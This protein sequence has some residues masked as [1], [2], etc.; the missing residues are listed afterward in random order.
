MTKNK[1]LEII[2]SSLKNNPE[3]QSELK[4]YLLGER[5]D[6]PDIKKIKYNY[7]A[8]YG[9]SY[10]KVFSEEGEVLDEELAE[11][12]KKVAISLS[13][14][15]SFSWEN[16]FAYMKT[17]YSIFKLAGI[18]EK[19]VK[20]I[21]EERRNFF[22]HDDLEKTR[23]FMIN[24]KELV[25][26]YLKNYKDFK[27]DN[28]IFSTLE[29]L[30][31]IL[32]C[33]EIGNKKIIEMY[34]NLKEE[35]EKILE[36]LY[37]NIIKN[38]FKEIPTKLKEVM[39]FYDSKLYEKFC[40]EG[41]NNINETTMK[42]RTQ[43]IKKIIYFL[44][45]YNQN[46]KNLSR[47]IIQ[48]KP[49]DFF[50][51]ENY[52]VALEIYRK[53]ELPKDIMVDLLCEKVL[54]V[55][56]YENYSKNLWNEELERVLKE[57]LDYLKER[58]EREKI[59]GNDR[60]VLLLAYGLKFDI[61]SEEKK[62]EYIERFEKYA[63]N[64][65][66]QVLVNNKKFQ[67]VYK[68]RE[69]SDLEILKSK[70]YEY[71]SIEVSLV[72]SSVFNFPNEFLKFS[73]LIGYF[74]DYSYIPINILK[75]TYD[76]VLGMW[77][78]FYVKTT[79]FNSFSKIT[80]EK[81]GY[82]GLYH[83]GISFQQ[84][85]WIFSLTYHLNGYYQ[86]EFLDLCREAKEEFYE[87]L[88][89][90]AGV[91]VEALEKLITLVYNGENKEEFEELKLL[92]I[93]NRKSKILLETVEK[94]LVKKEEK[95][96]ENVEELKTSK[97]K[98]ISDLAIRLI[99]VWDNDRIGKRLKELEEYSEI[100]KYIE[101][102]YTKSN[103][104][105]VPFAKEIDYTKIRWRDS[106]EKVP[107]KIVKY[108]ISEY[109]GLKEPFIINGCKELAEKFNIRD[110]RE[111]VREIFEKWR[112]EENSSAKYKNILLPFS[113]IANDVMLDLMK[114]QIDFLAQNSKPAIA[115]FAVQCLC[116]NQGK[117][118]LMLVDTMA[119][120]HKNKKI[121]KASQESLD[122]L[123]E[124]LEISKE[125][126]QDKIIPNFEF[127]RNRERFFDYGERKFRV[128][129]GENG[130]LVLFDE[131]GKEIK[132]LPKASSKYN[133]VEEKVNECKEELKSIKKQI[134]LVENQQKDRIYKAILT[135]RKWKVEDWK[136]LFIDNPIMNSFGIKV[137]WEEIDENEN[138]LQT[139]RYM[140]DG[141][142]NS[143]DED[144]CELREGSYIRGLHPVDIDK[145]ELES[146]KEQ[147]ED[148]NIV[149]PFEQLNLPIYKLKD[150][151]KEEKE[152]DVKGGEFY[153]STLKNV[154]EK[155]GFEISNEDYYSGISSTQYK[156]SN[157][158][159]IMVLKLANTVYYGEYTSSTSL[160]SLSFTKDGVEMMLKDVPKRLLN[161]GYFVASILN[162]KE[163]SEREE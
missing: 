77:G 15:T 111:F 98:A 131:K 55:S 18:S 20:R 79:L 62:K 138:I 24:Y 32:K 156:D 102:I 69:Y 3:Y 161:Y 91:E 22:I 105:N 66:R 75:L 136:T 26:T 65:C 83:R 134:K 140:E 149:Q 97:S 67:C 30:F 46:I 84:L 68:K 147:L 106:E 104:K 1:M 60:L 33:D 155:N 51:E 44:G 39:E 42:S 74:G 37:F 152:L 133:D 29:I 80:K 12:L 85:V 13:E 53:L 163:I 38:Q 160:E 8:N 59:F 10:L 48:L 73:N 19:Q 99:R 36:D 162:S 123:A 128:V 52:N 103:E 125:E 45:D 7:I 115:T 100:E 6:K 64:N 95:I 57:N 31:N 114:E 143:V 4:E 63:I 34:A 56:N 118:A 43:M 54:E 124:I 82:I 157:T 47:V 2:L 154:I 144:E 139:F 76:F 94:I 151:E 120:K 41:R 119:K 89:N 61:F 5:E 17:K 130:A 25:L 16:Y 126:L 146:W 159:I 108:Y 141:T 122:Y 113:L 14:I 107:E 27:M 72:S 87:F 58:I 71:G 101:S 35:A 70:D 93:V 129:L 158:G 40:E 28:K 81:N 96:R 11:M 116:L 9:L 135:G 86:K 78:H 127:N 109:M 145:E 142:F 117:R 112:V 90:C 153:F 110:L 92:P 121:K 148:Y 49:K 137:I 23:D 88:E 132:S 21:F 50:V 150:D